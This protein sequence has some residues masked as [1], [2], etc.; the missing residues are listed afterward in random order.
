MTSMAPVVK[1]AGIS[2]SRNEVWGALTESDI[3]AQWMGG[4]R[5]QSKWELGGDITFTGKLLKRTYRDRGTVL[6]IEREKLLKYN[7]SSGLSHLQDAPENRSMITFSL[8][9]TGEN[10]RLT[11][12]HERFREEAVYRHANYFWGFA[13]TELKHLLEGCAQRL[14]I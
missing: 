5:V 6:A 13:L 9:C 3:I 4:A 14:R 8:D 12:R 11:V 10:T 7:H 1:S 2:A